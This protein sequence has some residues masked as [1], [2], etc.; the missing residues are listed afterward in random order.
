M[1]GTNGRERGRELLYVVEGNQRHWWVI[2]QLL[3]FSYFPGWNVDEVAVFGAWARR[4][5]VVFDFYGASS[6]GARSDRAW[7]HRCLEGPND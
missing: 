2:E 4:G 3:W 5:A 7:L 6:L 1:R